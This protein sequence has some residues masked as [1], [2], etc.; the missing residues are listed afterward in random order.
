MR[1]TLT[2]PLI[3]LLVACAPD[4]VD[5]TTAADDTP[6]DSAVEPAGTDTATPDAPAEPIVALAATLAFA[7]AQDGVSPGFDLDATDGGSCSGAADFVGLDG[8]PGVDNAMSGLLPI[9]EAT[10][11]QALGELV[12]NAV[13]SGELM[14]LFEVDGLDGAQP[15]DAVD[16][17]IVRGLGAPQIGGEGTILPGQT[18]DR[19][20]DFPQAAVASAILQADGSV[21]GEGFD[22]RLPLQVFDESIDL[23]LKGGRMRLA[24]T[25]DGT[26][27]GEVAGGVEADE[28]AANVLGFDAIPE[29]LVSAITGALDLLADLPGTATD[30]SCSQLS[31]VVQFDT[32]SAYIFDEDAPDVGIEE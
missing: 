32:V 31:V 6:V 2:A 25:G 5:D 29:S 30:G 13:N 26:W 10:G 27:T 9:V 14:L 7:R 19:N 1:R 11:G 8:A 23:T 22:L 17:T 3:A 20:L 18:F 24:P 4:E 16:V 21:L 15:G 28:I 12:Q